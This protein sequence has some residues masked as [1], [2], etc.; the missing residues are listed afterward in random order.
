MCHCCC[1]GQYLKFLAFCGIYF[2]EIESTDQYQKALQVDRKLKEMKAAHR[3]KM[4]ER[5]V[6]TALLTE[7]L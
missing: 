7:A 5:E 6:R 2:D 1:S 3:R 4:K